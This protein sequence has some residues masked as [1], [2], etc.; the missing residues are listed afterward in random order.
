MGRS[1]V[2]EDEVASTVRARLRWLRE[3][4]H[5]S[6]QQVAEQTGLGKN[7][8]H[9]QETGAGRVDVTAL[10]RYARTY[11]VTTSWLLGADGCSVCEGKP[12]ADF[13]C[14]ACGAGKPLT[15]SESGA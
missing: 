13:T 7:T 9:R 4:H 5:W 8:V 6:I 10:V 2:V 3:R 11:H 12:P 15:D 14:N 1:R